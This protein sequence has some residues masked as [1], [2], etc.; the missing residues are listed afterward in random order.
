MKIVALYPFLKEEINALFLKISISSLY[1]IVDQVIIL[2]DHHNKNVDLDL[3]FLKQKKISIYY[4]KNTQRKSYAPR[5]EL[6]KLGRRNKGTHFIWLDCDEFFTYPFAKNGRKLISNLQIG[7]K[8]QLK[9]LNTWKNHRY[10]IDDKK[11]IYY[12]AYKDFIVYDSKGYAFPKKLIDEPRTQG[13]NVK[14]KTHFI[15]IKDGAVIHLQFVNWNNFKLKQA[16]YMCWEFI[17]LNS[18]AAKINRKYFYTYFNDFPKLKKINNKWIKNIPQ[19]YFYKLNINTQNYWSLR[20]EELF[21]NKLI[22][23]FEQ[24]NIWHNDILR[25]LFIRI[26]KRNPSLNIFSRLNIFLFFVL[27]NYRFIK[28]VIINNLKLKSGNSQ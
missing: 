19:K 5:D 21:H 4:T 11:N 27:E 2:I 14:E 6:L 16:W 12:H 13:V 15:N 8:I 7:E 10:Y 23:N 28:K 22:I 26:T 18:S 9:W 24:L 1:N 17:N 3:K 20:F 25:K